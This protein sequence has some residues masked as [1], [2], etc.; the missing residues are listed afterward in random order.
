MQAP[1]LLACP[2]CTFS[3]LGFYIV[4]MVLGGIPVSWMLL[5]KFVLRVRKIWG[6]PRITLPEII[7]LLPLLLLPVTMFFVGMQKHELARCIYGTYGLA[8]CVV[9]LWV[10]LCW[11]ME[12]LGVHSGMRQI[13]FPGVIFPGM[14]LAGALFGFSFLGTLAIGSFR[15][16]EALV[17]LV[18]TGAL[19]AA[20]YATLAVILKS[21]FCPDSEQ[22]PTPPDDSIIY[23]DHA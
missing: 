19:S 17:F 14:I 4:C 7:G 9:Y 1:Y 20:F 10:R 22:I 12:Q 21:V 23:I 18:V 3:A 11:L 6:M 5:R 13:M 2:G 16:G 15:P 8:L